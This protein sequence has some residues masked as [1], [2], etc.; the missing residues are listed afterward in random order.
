MQMAVLKPTSA[1]PFCPT[2]VSPELAGICWPRPPL[3]AVP[4]KGANCLPTILWTWLRR[5]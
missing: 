5:R 4:G 1:G 2:T 3:I